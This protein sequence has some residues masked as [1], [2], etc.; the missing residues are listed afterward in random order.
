MRLFSNNSKHYDKKTHEPISKKKHEID[1]CSLIAQQ[2]LPYCLMKVNES[3]FC[4]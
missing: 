1:Q 4:S 3:P 2:V